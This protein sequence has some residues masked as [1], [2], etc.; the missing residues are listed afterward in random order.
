MWGKIEP[1]SPSHRYLPRLEL[2]TGRLTIDTDMVTSIGTMVL[3]MLSDYVNSVGLYVCAC[4]WLLTVFG[5]MFYFCVGVL[6]YLLLSH[7]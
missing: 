5:F 7:R 3:R 2:H 1:P 4:V 6:V